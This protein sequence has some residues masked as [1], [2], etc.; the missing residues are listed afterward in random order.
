MDPERSIL[1]GGKTL[2]GLAWEYSLNGNVKPYLNAGTER[3]LVSDN[4]T[5]TNP[6]QVMS[7]W[8]GNL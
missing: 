8:T 6:D 2:L 1:A 7:L 4:S 3:S 5:G